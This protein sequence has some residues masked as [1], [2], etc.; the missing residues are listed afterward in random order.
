M[1]KLI[2]EGGRP[3]SGSV[4]VSGAKNAAIKMVAATLL[5][6]KPCILK[7]VPR[8]SDVEVMVKLVGGFGVLSSW[9]DDHTLA[10]NPTHI[11]KT[12]PDPKLV[13]KL[14]ASVVLIGPALAR[15]GEITL[16]FPGGDQIGRRPIETHLLAL[17]KLGV[18]VSNGS[19]Q[20][21]L[22]C[23]QLVGAKIFLQE[24]SVTATET[25]MMAATL[26]K[27]TTTIHVAASEPE[28]LNLAEFLNAMGARVVGAGTPTITVTGVKKLH[29]ATATVIPDRIEAGTLALA[30]IATKGT[31]TIKNVIPHHLANLIPRLEQLGATVEIADQ[32]VK[33]KSP[34]T[35]K[36]LKIDTRPYPGFSTD[37][38]SPMAAVLTQAHGTSTI[39]ETLFENRFNYVPP[40]NRMGARITIHQPHTIKITGPTTL[41]AATLQTRDIR[42]GAALVIAALAARGQSTIDGV[43]LIDRGYEKIDEKL[44]QL[45]AK[46]QRFQT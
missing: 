2:V 33:V 37:L 10:L 25:A 26:A 24:M 12:D 30:A 4:S 9:Q 46:I 44:R 5:A 13:R 23:N 21:H 3:L 6:T 15:F 16:P 18:T 43:N 39:F 40:L 19:N 36:T 34:A 31:V 41:R 45:G 38:Q 22:R 32:S 35:I 1:T 20:H 11:H 14:R 27:G 28:I 8:I 29:G 7:N 42:A 17:R